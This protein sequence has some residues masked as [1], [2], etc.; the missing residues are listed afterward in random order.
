MK[1]F[2]IWKDIWLGN[3]NELLLYQGRQLFYGYNLGVSLT[4]EYESWIKK[5]EISLK[6]WIYADI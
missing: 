4:M 5:E 6:S 1:L 3:K 2:K